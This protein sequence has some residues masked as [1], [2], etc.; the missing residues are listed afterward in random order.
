[1]SGTPEVSPPP[2]DK[3]VL[4]KDKPEE[5]KPATSS[6]STAG[7]ANDNPTGDNKTGTSTDENK[8]A[9][10]EPADDSA[11]RAAPSIPPE[12]LL[13]FTI[14][15]SGSTPVSI[16]ADKTK[17]VKTLD[18]KD[19]IAKKTEQKF[20]IEVQKLVF[21]GKVLTDDDVL[22]D[23]KVASGATVFLVKGTVVSGT[24]ASAA[25][26]SADGAKKEETKDDKSAEPVR[27]KGDC[28]FWGNPKTENYCSKCFTQKQQKDQEE[29]L[30]KQ[31]EAEEKEQKGEK[32]VEMKQG[33][34]EEEKKERP[35]QTD[36]TRCWVCNKKC[37]LAG[38]IECRCGYVFCSAH[39]LP[40]EHN[41]DF[42]YKATGR[43]LL[44]KQNNK[45]EADKLGDRA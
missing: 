37:K 1:M 31:K 4:N 34:D 2:E 41:C 5:E 16:E 26:S 14:K 11:S 39:R 32:D 45:V 21:K 7:N 3:L 27:C 17:C 8:D 22:A 6:S 28:G 18:L 42:D 24:S 10:D 40:E 23:K 33:D 44:R 29:I 36:K 19:L 30:K 20:P 43:E 15:V 38:A 35:V 9:K 13:T 25:S 12:N